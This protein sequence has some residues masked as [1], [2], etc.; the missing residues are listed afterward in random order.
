M[1]VL[2]IDQEC[3]FSVASV[4]PVSVTSSQAAPATATRSF[5]QAVYAAF[6]VDIKILIL[7]V[8]FAPKVNLHRRVVSQFCLGLRKI[9]ALMT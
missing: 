8:L 5:R 9:T 3:R 1:A 4:D 2:E 7:D 6:P